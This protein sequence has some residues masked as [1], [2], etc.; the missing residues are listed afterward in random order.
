MIFQKN[1]SR[2]SSSDLVFTGQNS[3]NHIRLNVRRYFQ[4][5]YLDIRFET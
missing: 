5:I 4:E 2:V 3:E 1:Y